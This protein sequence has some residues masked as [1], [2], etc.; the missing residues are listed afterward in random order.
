MDL[1]NRHLTIGQI[2]AGMVRLLRA[3]WPH[4]LLAG[5]MLAVIETVFIVGQ[6]EGLLADLGVNPFGS[7]ELGLAGSLLLAGVTVLAWGIPHVFLTVWLLHAAMP[8]TALSGQRR[9]PNWVRAY[10]AYLLTSVGIAVGF[11]LLIIPGVFLMVRW[12]TVLPVALFSDRPLTQGI[13]H[14]FESTGQSAWPITLFLVGLFLIQLSPLAIPT[15]VPLDS[16]AAEILL[17]LLV[18]AI[19]AGCDVLGIALSVSVT[20]GLMGQS[21]EAEQIFG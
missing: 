3:G 17:E 10:L 11:V 1:V 18:L 21:G 20:L 2:A 5:L 19:S 4:A 7:V 8:G 12:L 13:G 15:N 16:T 9:R 6:G 14:A